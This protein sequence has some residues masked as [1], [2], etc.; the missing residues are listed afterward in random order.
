M[1]RKNLFLILLIIGT[2]FWGVSY[3]VT[4]WAIGAASPSTFLFY[5]FLLATIVLSILFRKSFKKCTGA[6]IIASAGLAIPLL[7]SSYLLTLGIQATSASQAAFLTG[8]CVVLVPLLK[9]I[10]YR[11]AIPLQTWLAGFIA[12]TGLYIICIQDGFNIAGGDLYTIGAAL[13]FSLYLLNVERQAVIRDIIPTIAPMFAWC[14]LITGGIALADGQAN[15][16]P[17]HHEFWIGIV[18]CA[19]FS[20]AYMYTI[21]N[22]A[23]KFISAEK[24]AI[25]YLFEP[26]F[27]AIA[28]F[29]IVDESM[30]WRL[31]LGGCLIFVGTL[32]SE[33]K[34][35]RSESRPSL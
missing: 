29:F 18:Y 1:N 4:K 23:Q 5:R 20:T 15:W 28:A 12:L 32:I 8:I 31:L 9:L 6:T 17:V 7:T 33:M 3:P 30:T 16:M 21:S 35:T 27:G 2:A 24:V 14:A 11:T 10:F 13:S 19:L 25:I 34:K 26:V 22:I